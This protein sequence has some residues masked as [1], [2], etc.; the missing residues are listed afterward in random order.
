MFHFFINFNGKSNSRSVA[1]WQPGPLYALIIPSSSWREES[2][3][4]CWELPEEGEKVDGVG[5]GWGWG[6]W[7]EAVRECH[8]LAGRR[9]NGGGDDRVLNQVRVSGF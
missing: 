5:G 9:I 1:Q 2:C 7:C 8:R 4:S 3:L 6:E